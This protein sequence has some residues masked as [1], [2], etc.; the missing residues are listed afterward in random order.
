LVVGVV[1]DTQAAVLQ[2]VLAEEP[3]TKL[4]LAVLELLDKE[5]LE[6]M[7]LL[8]PRETVQV[9][10]AELGRLEQTAQPT[11]VMVVLVCSHP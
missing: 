8:H 5:T 4:A 2:V 10:V 11:V 1:E 6:V 7:E 3:Q 9:V